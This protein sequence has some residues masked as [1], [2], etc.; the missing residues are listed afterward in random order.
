MDRLLRLSYQ[1]YVYR[2]VETRSEACYR[3]LM[4]S[5]FIGGPLAVRGLLLFGASL[6]DYQV[7]SLHHWYLT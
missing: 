3:P 6:V 2:P 5:A 1:Y 7:E 4:S